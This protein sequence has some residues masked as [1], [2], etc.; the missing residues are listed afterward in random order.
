MKHIR[1]EQFA[2]RTWCEPEDMDRS[3]AVELVI[4]M[5]RYF[6]DEISKIHASNI[7]C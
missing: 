1:V 2:I 6:Q 5:Y 3:C 4:D 7:C